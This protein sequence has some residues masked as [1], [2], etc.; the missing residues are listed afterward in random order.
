[1]RQQLE[2]V[3]PALCPQVTLWSRLSARPPNGSLRMTSS[4]RPGS[5]SIEVQD[6]AQPALWVHDL[7]QRQAALTPNA[8]AVTCGSERLTYEELDHRSNR[9]AHYL[10]SLGITAGSVVGLCLE[11]SL[12]FPPAALAILKAGG[13]YLPF[14]T[15]TPSQRSKMMLDAAQV[16]VVITQASVMGSLTAD[17]RT[18]IALDRSAEEI[19]RC[20]SEPLPVRVTPGHLA[21]VIFTSG[22][23]G[24]PKGVAIGHDSLLNLIA[25]HNRTFSVKPADRATQLASIGFDAAVWELWPY[26][27]AGASV[28]IVDDES[29][30]D[31]QQLRDWLVREKITISFAPTPMAERMME[32]AWPKETALRFLLTGADTLHRHPPAKL[33]FTLVNNYG[34]TECTVVATSTAVVPQKSGE[35]LPPIG[36]PIDN[37]EILHSR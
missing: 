14:E 21:Y 17:P 19:R 24:I 31:P 29:R 12:D 1:M 23:T 5:G 6:A 36:R 37:T 2:G 34:P 20:S 33:P 4:E 10:R 26:L 30:A 15:K 9:L 35:Q 3:R 13:A 27:A 28:H 18:V 8:L 7:V 22:S 11:R 16:S 25:W 32:L